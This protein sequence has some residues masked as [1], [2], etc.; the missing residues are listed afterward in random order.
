MGANKNDSIRVHG[1]LV[2]NI[3]PKCNIHIPS[4][5]SSEGW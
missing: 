2:E 3:I 5:W 1:L 4:N